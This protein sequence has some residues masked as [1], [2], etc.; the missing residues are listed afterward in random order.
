[1]VRSSCTFNFN[2]F[3]IFIVNH[4]SPL[5]HGLVI[6]I[7]FV[8][9]AKRRSNFLLD[10]CSHNICHLV[11]QWI[12]KFLFALLFLL[13]EGTHRYE[14]LDEPFVGLAQLALFQV[15]FA[16]VN[17]V[18]HQVSKALV[19]TLAVLLREARSVDYV[20][21]GVREPVD[22]DFL[23]VQVEGRETLRQLFVHLVAP[24]LVVGDHVHAELV[25]SRL[26]NALRV[27]ARVDHLQHLVVFR[28]FSTE[29]AS[30]S[31]TVARGHALVF[32]VGGGVEGGV[33]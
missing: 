3:S 28:D 29:I 16:L 12:Q 2:L 11:S 4:S 10:N 30:R 19:E 26:E 22:A 25:L 27:E 14:L 21:L 9:V 8:L 18:D 32:Q 23:R 20:L 6:S 5:V 1:M 33:A 31:A 24:E 13:R 15:H 17:N 7:D